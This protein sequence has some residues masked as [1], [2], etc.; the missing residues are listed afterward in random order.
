[1]SSG[2]YIISKAQAADLGTADVDLAWVSQNGVAVVPAAGQRFQIL[3]ITIANTTAEAKSIH[4][5]QD[6]DAGNDLDA[7]ELVESFHFPAAIDTKHVSYDMP[8]PSRKIN[9]A[10]TNDL[11]LVASATGAVDYI[12]RAILL[13]PSS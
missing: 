10:G 2:Q 11:H 5:Y 1:M 12:V 9:A 8:V 4:L 6:L 13:S 7:G 3:S